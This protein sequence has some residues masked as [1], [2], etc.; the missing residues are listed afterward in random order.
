MKCKQKGCNRNA[1]DGRIY[2]SDH[3]VG[4][5]GVKIVR[6]QGHWVAKKAAKKPAAKKKK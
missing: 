6:R 1:E 5:G 4:G 2:C 3:P